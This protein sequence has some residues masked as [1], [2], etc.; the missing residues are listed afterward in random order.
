[1]LFQRADAFIDQRLQRLWLRPR[2]VNYFLIEDVPKQL[3][4]FL[5]QIRQLFEDFLN[6]H[7]PTVRRRWW[8]L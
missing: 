1:M 6:R 5:R 8:R 3:S 7:G 4:F 2:T